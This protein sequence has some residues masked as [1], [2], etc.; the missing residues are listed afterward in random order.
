MPVGLLDALFT[1][2][3]MRAV[4]SDR[5][6]LQRMLDF[7]AGLARAQARVGVIPPS[8]VPAIEAKCRAELFDLGAL[9]RATALA[10]NPAIP[11]VEQLTA[12]VAAD[13]PEAM[14]FVHW[15]ATSQD[16]MDTGLVLQLRDALNLLEAD[17]ARLST[18][19][20]Q[21]IT[22]HRLTPV[23]GR[24]WMQHALPVTFGL[25][26]AGW[27]DV[28]GRHRTRVRELRSRALTLQ[29]GGAV[30]TL[31]ALDARGLAVAG[32]L[33]DEL[34]LALPDLPWHAH[35]DRV[36]EVATTLGLLVGTLG[37]IARDI[38]LHM[39]TDV[40]EVFE[41]AEE[42]RGRSSTMPHKRNPVSCAVALAAAVRVPPLVSTMLAAMVQEHERGL[43]GWH[44]E[45]ETLPE[46]AMLSA[47]ALRQMLETV[48]GLEIDSARMRQNLDTTRGQILAEAVTM[49]LGSRL[50]RLAAHQLVEQ[51][52]HTASAQRR[53]LRE[54]LAENPVI[55]AQLTGE[56]LDRL[57]DPLN[58]VGMAE[59]LIDRVIAASLLEP[60]AAASDRE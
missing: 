59:V 40:A 12:L 33:A 20:A 27:L 29:F 22:D 58:S 47:G 9:G 1:T 46:I 44:A 7:E 6:R 5:V 15:G 55:T 8:A 3:A 42:G 43:G 26:V 41:P 17:L 60:S 56:E 48:S 52:C 23:V 31:A 4:F 16:P 54:V 38:S 37:K 10:G 39:Q 25:K 57:L 32:A 35:R 45:W 53:H 24:T 34:Q 30:G 21:R 13:D 50:G 2:D 36:G 28:I 19:L 51:A 18:A 14:R 11:M 49:A